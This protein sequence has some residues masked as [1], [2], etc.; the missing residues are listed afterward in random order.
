[1]DVSTIVGL[2]DRATIAVMTY[3]FARAGAVVA[4]A[5]EDYFPQKK[6]WW[7]PGRS[8]HR[9]ELA[10]TRRRSRSHGR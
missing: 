9:P 4:L 6:R 3:T 7:L 1:M 8:R 10:A 5:I 2:R